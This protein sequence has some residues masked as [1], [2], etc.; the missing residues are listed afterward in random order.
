[1]VAVVN[2]PGR[3]LPQPPEPVDVVNQQ[4]VSRA[5]QWVFDYLRHLDECLDDAKAAQRDLGATID[6][7]LTARNEREKDFTFA[8]AEHQR[9]HDEMDK[10]HKAQ[11][12]VWRTQWE[13]FREA[14][15]I[16]TSGAVFAIVAGA[17]K[18]A[19]LL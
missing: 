8:L 16:G 9:A 7:A 14:L 11:R 10:V 3:R 1:M 12:S 5:W 2:Y 15:K 18:L 19:G 17:L 4:W 13:W 6:A